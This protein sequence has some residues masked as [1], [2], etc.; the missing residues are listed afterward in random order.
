MKTL[1]FGDSFIGAFNLI[2]SKNLKIYK[3]KGKTIKGLSKQEDKD[4][5]KIIN[6]VNQNKNIKCIVFNFGQVDL[7]FSYYY[8]KFIKNDKKICRI[9]R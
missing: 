6:I 3:F 4:R 8:K 1:I 9:Y 2:E 7:Y 5:K